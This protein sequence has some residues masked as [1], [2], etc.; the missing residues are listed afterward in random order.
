MFKAAE[1]QD[2]E[3]RALLVAARA[4]ELMG[5]RTAM[6]DYATRAEKLCDGLRDR[7][8]ADAYSGYLRRPDIIRYRSQLA[9][10]IA[11]TK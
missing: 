5:N 3:W 10:M 7:W 2:S 6:Q 4:S 11:R 8:G 1:Q 9:K